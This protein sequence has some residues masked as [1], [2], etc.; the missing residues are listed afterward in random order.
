MSYCSRVVVQAPGK[1]NL[2]LDVV[3]TDNRGYHLLEMVMQSIDLSDLVL[4]GRGE[5]EEIRVT[6]SSSEIPEDDTNIVHSAAT[7]FFAETG[8]ARQGLS[9]HIDKRLPVQAGLAGGSADAAALLRGLDRLFETCLSR[10]Q[11]CEIGLKCGADVPFCIVGGCCYAQGVGEILTPLPAL[12]ACRI[13]VA[14]PPRGMSTRIAFGRYDKAG[15][16]LERPNTQ[17]MLDSVAAGNL[18]G[19]GQNMFN[20]LQQVNT[21]EEVEV[22]TGILLCDGALGAVMTGSG[23]AVIGLFQDSAQAKTARRHLREQVAQAWIAAPLDHG[24][25]LLH[26]S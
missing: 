14:K 1:V 4:I 7:H 17:A 16:D 8:L 12:P 6:C 13:A 9:V 11:L 5:R 20:V 2:S 26:V 23:T 18:A 22:L 15:K 19:V 25:Q 10:E 3:G 21:V 24:A